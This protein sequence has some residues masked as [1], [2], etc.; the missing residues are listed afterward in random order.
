[1][2]PHEI[3]T[4]GAGYAFLWHFTEW[5]GPIIHGIGLAVAIWA[6]RRSRKGGYIVLAF[7][8]ALALFVVLAMPSIN[9]AIRERG[10][11]DV[12]EQTEKKIEEEV[13]HT[14]DRVMT[15]GGHPI[16]AA[17]RTANVPFGPI[18]LVAGLWLIARRELRLEE[19]EGRTE[20]RPP[21]S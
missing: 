14:I 13:Q 4:S 1:M 19:S 8:F 16:M 15:E 5:L 21:G 20:Q 6:F 11:P 7:Y 12:S 17:R 2:S 3:P 9:R 18:V 10:Q